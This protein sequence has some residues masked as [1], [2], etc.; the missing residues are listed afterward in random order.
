MV[1]KLGRDLI[2]FLTT[3]QT[4]GT[5]V[6]GGGM[7]AATMSICQGVHVDGIV[8]EVAQVEIPLSRVPALAVEKDL[9]EQL[10]PATQTKKSAPPAL[11]PPSSP[12]PVRCYRTASILK[13]KPSP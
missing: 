9:R 10:D 5:Q 1:K 7:Q 3:S 13:M 8:A 2:N 4:A 12:P 11:G 6:L